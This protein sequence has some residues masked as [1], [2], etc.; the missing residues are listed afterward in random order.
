M[1]TPSPH[2]ITAFFRDRS[3]AEQ[4]TSE[5]ISAGIPQE[6]IRLVPGKESDSVAATETE[7][8]SGFWDAL[9]DFFFPAED[10]EVYA[11]GLR[12]GGYLVTVTNLDATQHETALDIL[13]DEGTIDVDQWSDSWRAEGWTPPRTGYERNQTADTLRTRQA[14]S[15]TDNAV[16]TGANT[17]SDSVVGTRDPAVTGS[18]VRS[19]VYGKPEDNLGTPPRV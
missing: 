4:A 14:A 8:R 6:D 7:Q 9:A 11:E 5:L 10:R 19:Y 1:D 3:D 2:T 17:A 16:D 12:R 18:R 13:D 15:S